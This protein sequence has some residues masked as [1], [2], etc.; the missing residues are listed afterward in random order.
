MA[1][2]PHVAAQRSRDARVLELRF[3]A[4]REHRLAMEVRGSSRP[5]TVMRFR[6]A[7]LRV[8]V[9]V[10]LGSVARRHHPPP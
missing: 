1:R 5:D 3:N 6:P 7:H 2:V 9:V 4:E 10:A 8:T